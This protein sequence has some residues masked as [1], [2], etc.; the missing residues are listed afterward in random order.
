VKYNLDFMDCQ[1]ELVDANSN[2]KGE[3]VFAIKGIKTA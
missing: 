2:G 1:I 3:T